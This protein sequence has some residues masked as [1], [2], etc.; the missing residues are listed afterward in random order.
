MG[1]PLGLSTNTGPI[2]SAAW[3]AARELYPRDPKWRVEIELAPATTSALRLELEIYA[4]EWGF[5]FSA[6]ERVS[7]IRV[8]DVPFVHGRD[9]HGL[10]RATPP[11]RDIGML[12]RSLETSHA[13]AFDRRRAA[14]RTTIDGG[15]PVIRSWLETL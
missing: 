6:G 13:I 5:R 8:T 12:V 15:E 7:W 2:A 9:D 1:T 14:I 11:L 10:L 3:L 4:E